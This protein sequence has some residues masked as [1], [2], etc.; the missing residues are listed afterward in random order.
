[1]K[2]GYLDMPFRDLHIRRPSGLEV[3]LRR[4]DSDYGKCC[5]HCKILAIKSKAK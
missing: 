2:E 3:G 1:M 4:L 5:M